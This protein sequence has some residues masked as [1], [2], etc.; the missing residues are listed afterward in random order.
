MDPLQGV[1]YLA[2]LADI[3]GSTKLG[4]SRVKLGGGRSSLVLAELV[5][6]AWS[7]FCSV[8]HNDNEAKSALDRQNI[9][10]SN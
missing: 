8:P 1:P 7:N 9:F 2:K 6:S 10:S 4:R 5:A 3:S